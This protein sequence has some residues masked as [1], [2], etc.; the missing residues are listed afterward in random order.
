MFLF[1]PQL[2]IIKFKKSQIAL[3]TM[4]S[5]LGQ[6]LEAAALERKVYLFMLLK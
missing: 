3:C 2:K 1:H 4:V 6:L 5:S